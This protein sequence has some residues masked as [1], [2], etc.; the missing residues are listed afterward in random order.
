MLAR[1]VE[2]DFE[3]SELRRGSDVASYLYLRE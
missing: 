2:G 3:H 1:I